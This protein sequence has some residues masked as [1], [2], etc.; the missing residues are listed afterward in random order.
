MKEKL[1]IIFSDKNRSE[2]KEEGLIIWRDELHDFLVDWRSSK[3]LKNLANERESPIVRKWKSL[4]LSWR[5]F[6]T[7][8]FYLA[9]ASYYFLSGFGLSGDEHFTNTILLYLAGASALTLLTKTQPAFTKV[10]KFLY[11]RANQNQIYNKPVEPEELINFW[12][13]RARSFLDQ[14]ENALRNQATDIET[15]IREA[16]KTKNELIQNGDPR[17]ELA[18]QKLEQRTFELEERK[19]EL[20]E[21]SAKVALLR[22][23]LQEK[24]QKLETTIEEFRLIQSQSEQVNLLLKRANEILD[25]SDNHPDE[26][27]ESQGALEEEL[28]SLTSFIQEELLLST[29]YLQSQIEFERKELS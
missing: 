13:Q 29:D 1:Q 22:T 24:I 18:I 12:K 19:R 27:K 20:T 2:T 10:Q 14:K 7:T 8:L 4:Y 21:S 15:S 6:L 23:R 3:A 11:L 17:L 28:Y 25:D 9:P 26:L 5:S 16:G